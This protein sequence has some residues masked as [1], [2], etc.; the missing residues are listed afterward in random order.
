MRIRYNLSNYDE[1]IN[2]CYTAYSFVNT[3]IVINNK[4][5][6]KESITRDHTLEL[7]QDYIKNNWHT[8]TIK[9][10]KSIMLYPRNLLALWIQESVR[11]K[12]DDCK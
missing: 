3:D 12:L 9:D 8:I 2:F 1:Y 6:I 11:R 4:T 7:V 10:T 5:D